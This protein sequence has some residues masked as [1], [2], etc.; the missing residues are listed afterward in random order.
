MRQETTIPIS[1]QRKKEQIVAQLSLA[2]DQ[3]TDLSPKGSL[4]DA[5]CPLIEAINAQ[6]GLVTTSSC[7][8]RIS[9][10]LEGRKTATQSPV[11]ENNIS[12]ATQN[13]SLASTGGKGGGGRWLYVSHEPVSVPAAQE[14]G[15][16]MKLYALSDPLPM[17]DCKSMSDVRL[18][19]FKFEPMILHILTATLAHAQLVLKSAIEAG[20]RESGAI[21]L[22]NSNDSKPTPMVA[23]RTLGLGFDSI[24]GYMAEQEGSR[25][26]II[27]SIVTEGYLHI[28]TQIANKKFRDNTRRMN[29]FSTNL[30]NLCQSDVGLNNAS[31]VHKPLHQ[32][33]WEDADTRRQRKRAEGLKKKQELLEENK[34]RDN[35][36]RQICSEEGKD[37]LTQFSGRLS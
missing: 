35:Q 10:F 19:H 28:L 12:L 16:F 1:F 17:L 23:V 3:Y 29:R 26:E 31:G 13:T 18:V 32:V 25:N 33:N 9:V 5:I 34:Q 27:R 20:F 36:S 4:D 24:I 30:L 21:N 22:V 8:G 11:Q 2:N 7:A 6:N 37:D 14:D 15:R